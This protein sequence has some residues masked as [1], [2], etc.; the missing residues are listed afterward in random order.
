MRDDTGDAA[1]K[2]EGGTGAPIRIE[3]SISGHEG[4]WVD[5]ERKGWKYRHLAEWEEAP[6]S[7]AVSEVVAER[8]VGWSLKDEE[9]VPVAFRPA[10]VE[11]ALEAAT[12]EEDRAELKVA[13]RQ[14][15]REC[16]YELEPEIAAFVVGAF[17][18]AY[19]QAGLP[20]PKAS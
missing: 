1:E 5:F 4:E 7:R 6:G 12:D 10:D 13:L 11:K 20:S 3:C 19:Y 2:R 8:I 14:A 16:L 9:G 15:R 17:R 18:L